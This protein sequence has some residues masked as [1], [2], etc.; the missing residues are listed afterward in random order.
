MVRGPSYSD[1]EWVV[2]LWYFMNRPEPEHTDSH[3]ACM[4]LASSIGRTPGSV[5]ASLRNIKNY[6][7]DAGFSHGAERMLAVV[8]EYYTQP[9]ALRAAA[10]AA[11]GR[12]NPN[13][14]LP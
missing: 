3:P 1:D 14:T 5:D 7:A 10:Q 2:L 4:A 13:A 11:L 8:D 9:T 12:I 6:V